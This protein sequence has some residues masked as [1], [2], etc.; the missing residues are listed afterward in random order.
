MVLIDRG[1]ESAADYLDDRAGKILRNFLRQQRDP[2]L[3]YNDHFAMVGGYLARQHAH[4]C[5]FAR[6]VSPKQANAIRYVNLT[7]NVVQKC[8]AAKADCQVIKLQERH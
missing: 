4:E 7:G 8:R 5:R 2:L 1:G 3:G 6:A